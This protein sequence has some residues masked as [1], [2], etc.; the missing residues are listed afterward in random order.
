MKSCRDHFA[1]PTVLGAG[2][3][4]ILIAGLLAAAALAGCLDD[5][6]H[7]DAATLTEAPDSAAPGEEVEACWQVDGDGEIEHVALHWDTESHAGEN[8]TFSDYENLAW[9]GGEQQGNYT[10]PG[11]FCATFTMPSSDAYLRGHAMIDAPGV[12]TAEHHVQLS[13]LG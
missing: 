6:P 7:I 13:A 12:L 2:A 10:L 1:Y 5:D 11:E 9:P 4:R 8:A 3:M